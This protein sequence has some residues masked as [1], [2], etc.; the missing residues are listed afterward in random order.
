MD[1]DDYTVV[2]IELTT[3]S[4]IEVFISNQNSSNN[5]EHTL[6]VNGN[7]TKWTGPFLIK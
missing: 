7:L 3:G 2:K 6:T 4:P 1:T 5:K